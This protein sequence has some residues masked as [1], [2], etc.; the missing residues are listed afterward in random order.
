[1]ERNWF[2]IIGMF[3]F[4]IAGVGIIFVGISTIFYQPNLVGSILL[5]ILGGMVVGS[6]IVVL[7]HFLK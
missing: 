7:Y 3:L 2:V 5:L 4:L 1:M 6:A